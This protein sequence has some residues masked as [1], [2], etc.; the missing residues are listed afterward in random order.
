MEILA[1]ASDSATSALTQVDAVSG[2][3]SEEEN[4]QLCKNLSR[5]KICL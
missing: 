5:R 3:G 4:K 1:L 2:V